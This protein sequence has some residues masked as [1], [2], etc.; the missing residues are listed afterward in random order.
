MLLIFRLLQPAEISSWRICLQLL[1][2]SNYYF[3]KLILILIL[4][5]LGILPADSAAAGFYISNMWNYVQGNAA[6]GGWAGFALPHFRTP[7]GAFKDTPFVIAP[8]DKAALLFDGN[9]AHSSGYYFAI[10]GG[11]LYSGG[12]KELVLMYTHVLTTRSVVL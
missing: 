6:S 8:K 7:T 4:I 12:C 9:T 3:T 1:I 11:C 2:V 5:L 10:F